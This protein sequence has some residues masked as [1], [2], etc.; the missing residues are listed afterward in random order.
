MSLYTKDFFGNQFD[1]KS[2]KAKSRGKISA[3]FA[4][5]D[6]YE[7][8]KRIAADGNLPKDGNKQLGKTS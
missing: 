1:T 8:R 7:S 3:P 2:Q 5:R 6:L 4:T